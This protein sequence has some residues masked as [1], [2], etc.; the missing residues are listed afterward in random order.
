MFFEDEM[1]IVR[2][3]LIEAK[4]TKIRNS[5]IHDDEFDR[6]VVHYWV[7]LTQKE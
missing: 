2:R 7:W 1:K 3:L 6:S 4:H 5:T